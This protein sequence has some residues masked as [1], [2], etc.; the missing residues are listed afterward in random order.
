MEKPKEDRVR[1][2]ITI[3]QKLKEV[4][5]PPLDAGFQ[6]IQAAVSEWV[7]TGEPIAKTVPFSRMDRIAEVILPR[8][9]TAIASIVLRVAK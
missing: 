3:L 4:G 9:R 7:K 8:K 2:G 1:E 6:E 5:V